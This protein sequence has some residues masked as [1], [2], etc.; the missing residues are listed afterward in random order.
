MQS[1]CTAITAEQLTCS[2]QLAATGASP[3]PVPQRNSHCL[4]S[5]ARLSNQPARGGDREGRGRK[6]INMT[7]GIV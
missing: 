5:S 3:P 4:S 1:M 7:V 2:V 6:G